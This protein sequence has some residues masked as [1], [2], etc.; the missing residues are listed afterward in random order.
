LS[1]LTVAAPARGIAPLALRR[2]ATLVYRNYVVQR[3]ARAVLTIFLIS[4]MTFFLVRLLPGNPVDTYIS[5]LIGLYGMSYADASNQA[6]G[7][8]AFNPNEPL[9]QQYWTYLQALAHG[10]LGRPLLSQG[11]TRGRSSASASAC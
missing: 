5:T 3:V 6:A 10:D 9:G 11:T 4:T 7:L 2:A 8:F 1:S